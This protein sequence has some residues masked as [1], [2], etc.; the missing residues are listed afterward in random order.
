MLSMATAAWLLP[1]LALPSMAGLPALIQAPPP[2]PPADISAP[3]VGREAPLQ[4]GRQ[5]RLGGQ[6]QQARWQLR[7]GA[8]GQL[9]ELWLPLEVLQNQLGMASRSQS[10]G[11]L[12]LE[13]YGRELEVPPTCQE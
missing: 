7:Q 6:L 9:V 2:L 1:L 13:W 8:A 4:S 5:L 10:S 3:R 12:K 11:A